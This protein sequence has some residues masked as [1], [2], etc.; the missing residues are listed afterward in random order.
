MNIFTNGL[1]LDIVKDMLIRGNPFISY[2]EALSIAQRL[3]FIRMRIARKGWEQPWSV[4]LTL[5][6]DKTILEGTHKGDSQDYKS[7]RSF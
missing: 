7:K 3:K 2:L 5:R 6:H 4:T 1:R